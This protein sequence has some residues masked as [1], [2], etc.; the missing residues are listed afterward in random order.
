MLNTFP[1]YIFLVLSHLVKKLDALENKH[2]WC[3]NG[4]LNGCNYPL[5]KKTVWKLKQLNWHKLPAALTTSK[6]ILL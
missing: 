5:K 2:F 4:S 1:I 3:L 6:Q